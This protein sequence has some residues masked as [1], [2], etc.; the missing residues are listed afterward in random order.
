MDYLKA[1]AIGGLI[2]A[3]AQILIDKTRLTPG[4]ILVAFVVLGAVLG[5]MGI[6]DSIVDFAGAG[7][8]VPI[9]GFG[10][11]LAKG[12]IKAVSEKGLLGALL[13]GA[14]AA[15]GGISASILFGFLAAL[16]FSPKSKS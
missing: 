7:A 12:A 2:C 5:G 15:A 1:F 16:I 3:L 13:G 9:I 10:N 8:T 11:I 14:E 4:R 6:Y